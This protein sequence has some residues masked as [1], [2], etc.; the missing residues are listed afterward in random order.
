VLTAGKII[1]LIK[2]EDVFQYMDHET[3]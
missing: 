1:G 3:E 2:L